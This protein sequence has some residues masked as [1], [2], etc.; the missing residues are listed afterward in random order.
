MKLDRFRQKWKQNGNPGMETKVIQNKVP[1]ITLIVVV[2]VEDQ[3]EI[4]LF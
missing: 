1:I 2:F 4:N 3:S